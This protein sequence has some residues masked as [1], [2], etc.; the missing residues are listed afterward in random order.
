MS[1][2]FIILS[3]F[4]LFPTLHSY[5][6]AFSS[7]E[8]DE[9]DSGYNTIV[10]DKNNILLQSG[11]VLH[12][13]DVYINED[14]HL[15]EITSI[16]GSLAIARHI[17]SESTLSLGTE[18]IPAQGAATAVQ[19][20]IAIYHTHTDESYIPTDGKSSDPGKG[21]IMEVGDSFNNRLNELGYQ[22]LHSKTLHEPH[23]ANAYQ[24]SRRTFMKLL[25]HQPVA[26]FDLHRDSG[27][28]A[29]YQTTINGQNVAKILLVVGRQNQN[30]ATTLQYAKTIKANADTT[31]KGLIRGIFIARG[32]YNQDL[33]PQSMLVE[34]GTQY[35]TKEAAQRSAALFADIIPSIIKPNPRSTS[36][37][38][39]GTTKTLVE[40]T[41]AE[42]GT[43]TAPDAETKNVTF[44]YNILSII[45]VVF[46]SIITYLYLSTGSWQEAKSKLYK[47][48]KYEFTNFLGSRKKGKD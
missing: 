4:L 20:L 23:D 22:T 45:G 11:L 30:H 21:S 13:G 18:F 38:T 47:F 26:L 34:M 5:T 12:I 28:L 3:T 9:L 43:V 39:Q 25:G 17:T 37:L 2:F 44:T 48:C 31:Y 36:P 15:Y 1:F 16:E 8:Q 42:D 35:N 19:S 6:L 33:N 24:R 7:P 41:S 29:S 32:N 10:D 14:D 46:I 40:N 27:P